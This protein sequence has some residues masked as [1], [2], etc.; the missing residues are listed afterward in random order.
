MGAGEHSG[1]GGVNPEF[2]L[3]PCCSVLGQWDLVLAMRGPGFLLPLKNK[4]RP[5]LS[6]TLVAL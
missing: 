2:L 1:Q 6:I 4:G 3:T 5:W